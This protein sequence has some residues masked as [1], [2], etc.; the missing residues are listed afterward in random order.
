MHSKADLCAACGA[1][2]SS[3]IHIIALYYFFQVHLG[4]LYNNIG[5]N[6]SS[7]FLVLYSG[8][9]LK[10]QLVNSIERSGIDT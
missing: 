2:L 3:A 6:N 1:C 5:C 4:L 10:K 8:V 7:V 9:N